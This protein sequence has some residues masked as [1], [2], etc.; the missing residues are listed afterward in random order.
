[1]TYNVEAIVN[2]YENHFGEYDDL[3][4]TIA[5]VLDRHPADITSYSVGRLVERWRAFC[6]NPEGYASTCVPDMVNLDLDACKPYEMTAGIDEGDAESGPICV[7]HITVCLAESEEE[8]KEQFLK[9]AKDMMGNIVGLHI[10]EM[11][12]SE[13][14]EW[15]EQ[16]WIY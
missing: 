14:E 1:M 7:A 3:I 6:E 15:K 4:D 5:R 11:S 10:R 9:D 13:Y 8:A 12:A 2:D 16:Y